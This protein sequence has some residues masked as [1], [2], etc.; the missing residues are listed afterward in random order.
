MN[1]EKSSVLYSVA[2]ERI[3]NAFVS[4]CFKKHFREIIDERHQGEE[5]STLFHFL[6]SI[7]DRKEKIDQFRDNVNLDPAD[8]SL[9]NS[10][11]FDPEVNHIF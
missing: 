2:K 8:C 10:F 11:S 5:F 3:P 4:T 9:L 1:E 7:I 6:P